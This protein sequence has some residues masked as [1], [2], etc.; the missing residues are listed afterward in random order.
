VPTPRTI[1]SVGQIRKAGFQAKYRFKLKSFHFS[2]GLT[3]ARAAR[4]NNR[5][6]N[7][8]RVKTHYFCEPLQPE[9]TP[10]FWPPAL[11]LV[12]HDRIDHIAPHAWPTVK[13]P[14]VAAA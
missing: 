8:F 11:L 7:G 3:A 1:A 6:G 9:S 2:D 5:W 10:A 13:M 14:S 4:A 12:A